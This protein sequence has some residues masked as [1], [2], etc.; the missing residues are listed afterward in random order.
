M[1]KSLDSI[2]FMVQWSFAES[3]SENPDEFVR[4]LKAYNKSITSAMGLLDPYRIFNFFGRLLLD[5]DT[6]LARLRVK[7]EYS[8]ESKSGDLE[9]REKVIEIQ[10]TSGTLTVGELVF[11]IHQKAKRDLAGQDH[12]HIESIDLIDDGKSGGIPTYELFLGS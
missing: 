7:Y 3:G 1:N 8:V 6:K 11:W 4:E 12:C 10:S 5:R 2:P 9:D